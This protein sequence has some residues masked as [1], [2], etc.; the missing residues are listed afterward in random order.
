MQIYF[1]FLILKRDFL[2]ALG[3]NQYLVLVIQHQGNGYKH[4]PRQEVERKIGRFG[5]KS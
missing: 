5:F 4:I 1:C 2:I 3:E